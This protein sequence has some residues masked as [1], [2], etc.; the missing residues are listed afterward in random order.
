MLGASIGII[1]KKPTNKIIGNINAFAAGLMLSIVM[2]D[3]IPEAI[4]NINYLSS[5]LL[6]FAGVLSIALIDIVS[7]GRATFKT[8]HNKIAFMAAAGLMI[9]NFPEGIIMGV[10]FLARGDL[11]IKMSL[12]IVIHDIPEGIAIAAPLMAAKVKISKIIRYAFITAL[13]T[14]IGGWL[15]VCLGNISPAFLGGC[16][17]VA[18]GIML[19]VIFGEMLPE[20]LK[21]RSGRDI[22]FSIFFGIILGLVITN[23]L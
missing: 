21:L 7:S 12:L 19:Y 13:P 5:I 17:S 4:I 6:S 23:I 18:S 14:V 11:G 1:I 2:L 22:T 8:S 15:G 20:A 9:H 16:L 3:L 10:G